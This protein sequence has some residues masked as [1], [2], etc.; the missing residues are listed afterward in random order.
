MHGYNETKHVDTGFETVQ[1]INSV[2]LEL[3]KWSDVGYELT[4]GLET[5]ACWANDTF[6]DIVTRIREL[7][8]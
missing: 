7:A 3:Q 5:I 2:E 8:G 4:Q 1:M 6:G